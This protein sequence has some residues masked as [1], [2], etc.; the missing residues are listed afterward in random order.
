MPK[1]APLY[2]HVPKNR[3]TM[4][5]LPQDELRFLPDSSEFLAE[6]ITCTGCREKL[7]SV[8]L[9]AIARAKGRK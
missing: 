8:F 2:P 9:Q 5:G 3:K 6:T 1:K 4:P 7:D